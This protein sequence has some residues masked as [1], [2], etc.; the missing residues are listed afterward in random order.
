MNELHRP[1]QRLAVTERGSRVVRVQQS[2]HV[3][4]QQPPRHP[5]DRS[6]SAARHWSVENRPAGRRLRRSASR[7]AGELERSAISARSHPLSGR[8]CCDI[9]GRTRPICS[10][11]QAPT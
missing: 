10:Q 6:N 2:A 8:S 4:R 5:R 7:S 1:S 11:T 3:D 9:S